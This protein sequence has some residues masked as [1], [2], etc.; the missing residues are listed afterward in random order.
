MTP[1]LRQAPAADAADTGLARR[2]FNLRTLASFVAAFALLAFL[3]SRV[4]FDVAGTLAVIARANAGLFV[5]GLVI[6]YT[7]FVARGLRWRY[8][9]RNAGF[10]DPPSTPVLGTI[11][12]LSWFVNCLVPAKLGDVYRAFLLRKHSGGSLTTAGGTIVAERIIDFAFVLILI[13]A[14]ALAAFRGHVPEQLQPVLEIGGAGVLIAGIGMLT[15]RRWETLIP[16]F[17]PRRFHPVYER[18]HVGTM[19]AFGSYGW[20]LLYTPLGWLAEILR[21]WLVALA[22]GLNLGSSPWQQFAVAAFVALASALLTSAAPTPGGLGAAEAGIVFALKLFN[23]DDQVAIAAAL[24]DRLIS[25]WSLVLVGF[26]VYVL[27]ETRG[28]GPALQR[29]EAPPGAGR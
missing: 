1:D 6:Y 29:G 27:W 15:L 20:L 21:F 17:L 5:I 12:L 22:V 3:F 23:V 14:S 7:T 13:G 19:S 16:R 4:Q 10:A 28:P 26:V 25:Y 24:L 18:F 9:L 8:M 11:I 2:F